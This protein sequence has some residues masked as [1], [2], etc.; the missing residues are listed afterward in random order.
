MAPAPKT[1]K[2][3]PP[4]SHD[5]RAQARSLLES[6]RALHKRVSVGS[7]DK[8]D[9]KEFL[10]IVGAAGVVLSVSNTEL[11]ELA[12]R[13]RGYVANIVRKRERVRLPTM[14]SLLASVIQVAEERLEGGETVTIG[15]PLPSAPPGA[16]F[17]P[18]PHNLVEAAEIAGLLAEMAR[19]ELV[20]LEQL[21][22]NDPDQ[23][24]RDR[25]FAELLKIFAE[26]F[27][28]LQATIRIHSSGVPADGTIG[29]PS[30]QARSMGQQLREWIKK[31][32]DVVDSTV[33]MSL[34]TTA[35]ATLNLAG[36]NMVIG[37]AL[38]AAAFLRKE[39]LEAV[40]TVVEAVG[41]KARKLSK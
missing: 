27:E 39:T 36:A 7:Y 3:F 33:R 9:H 40:S 1:F 10:R 6:A 35:C 16:W 2:R 21:R 13:S 4:A 22:T 8:T 11:S 17:P 25:R 32:P 20:N 19:R 18:A 31:N 23:I 14:L 30:N 26:G 5:L 41:R 12:G 34:V 28:R 15:L 29:S 38:S 24:E 37:T